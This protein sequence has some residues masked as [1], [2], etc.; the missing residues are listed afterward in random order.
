MKRE[1]R[2]SSVLVHRRRRSALR[3]G[4]LVVRKDQRYPSD[5]TGLGSPKDDLDVLTKR[6]TATSAGNRPAVDQHAINSLY[7]VIPVSTD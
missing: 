7:R 1:D 6:T 2:F 5:I 3:S 4:M